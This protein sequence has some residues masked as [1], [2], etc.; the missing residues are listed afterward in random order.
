MQSLKKSK[1]RQNEVKATVN[2]KRKKK[3][4]SLRKLT[5]CNSQNI[6]HQFSRAYN[7]SMTGCSIG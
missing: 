4:Q 7:S 1:Q 3:G 6:E 2:L 5:L